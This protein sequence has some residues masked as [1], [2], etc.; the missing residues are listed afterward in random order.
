MSH[1]DQHAPS[2]APSDEAMGRLLRLV[3]PRPDVPAERAAR[4]HV[5]VRTGWLAG[6]RERNRRRRAAFAI[7]IL[8]AAAVAMFAIRERSLEPPAVV[9]SGEAVAAVERMEGS[10]RVTPGEAPTATVSLLSSSTILAGDWIETDADARVALR[11][12]SGSSMRIDSGSRVRLMSPRL[13]ELMHGALYLSTVENSE[14]VEVRTPLGNAHDI[15]TD[16][17]VR[18]DVAALRL[19]VRSGLVELRRGGRASQAH[20]GEELTAT[21]DAVTRRAVATFGPDWDWITRVAPPLEIDGR[22]LSAV[23]SQVSREQGWTLRYADD[24]LARDASTILL[25]GSVVGLQALDALAVALK[26]SGLAHRLDQGVLLVSRS[27]GAPE[28]R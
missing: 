21:A 18:L 28:N 12:D 13:I 22:T 20:V 27:S 5:A 6:V 15:G 26:T 4:V 11:L 2:P 10:P 16:F 14:G 23:L 1:P 7:T 17:E 9:S 3:G 25:H 8:G 24:E 19:R